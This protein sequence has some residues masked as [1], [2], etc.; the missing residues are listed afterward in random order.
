MPVWAVD[1]SFNQP[2]LL[3]SLGLQGPTNKQQRNCYSIFIMESFK[4]IQKYREEYN[5]LPNICHT[6]SKI[7]NLLPISF[8]LYAHLPHPQVILKQISVA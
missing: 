8:Y 5:E 3:K 1:L 4:Y 2:S 7:I 6:A